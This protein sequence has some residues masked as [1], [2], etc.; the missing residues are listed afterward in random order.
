[1]TAN[2]I[3]VVIVDGVDVSKADLR[4]YEKVYVRKVMADANEVRNTVLV[5]QYGGLNVRSLSSSYDIDVADM[6]T[7]DDGVD[8]II[9]FDG[10][11]FKRVIPSTS[12]TQ[13]IVTVAGP[14]T[15]GPTDEIVI[16][17]KAVGAATIV[18]VDWS[19]QTKPL[20]IVDGKPDAATHNISIVPAAGQTQYGTVD[21]VVVIDGDGGQVTLT[22]LADGS[23]GF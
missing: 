7:A 20:T 4:A 16:I 5:G 19:L 9:S 12:R 21:Y 6:T 17:K 22:P 23:G 13:R 2:P 3:D 11:R 18:N 14:V 10:Y 15:I 8:C 1:M